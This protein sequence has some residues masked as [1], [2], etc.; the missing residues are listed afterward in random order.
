MNTSDSVYGVKT[1][2]PV[3]ELPSEEVAQAFAEQGTL[4]DPRPGHTLNTSRIVDED[5]ESLDEEALEIEQV[6]E[7]PTA[8]HAVYRV[9]E[10][11]LK[12]VEVDW[13]LSSEGTLWG[14]I[15]SRDEVDISATA[16]TLPGFE[17]YVVREG[18]SELSSAGLEKLLELTTKEKE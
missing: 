4:Q 5:M 8:L 15:G 9:K 3:S 6:L 10:R 17:G 14:F 2:R 13:I 18:A 12:A 1:V 7:A 11:L 16:E